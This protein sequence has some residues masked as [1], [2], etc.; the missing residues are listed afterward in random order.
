MLSSNLTTYN[1]PLRVPKLELKLEHLEHLPQWS[2]FLVLRHMVRRLQNKLT[3]ALTTLTTISDVR[4]PTSLTGDG[5]DAMYANDS[6]LNRT[7]FHSFFVL[8]ITTV[9]IH[10]LTLNF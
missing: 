6:A 10:L 7:H 5:S 3:I 2:R 8:G 1:L 4:F 9:I